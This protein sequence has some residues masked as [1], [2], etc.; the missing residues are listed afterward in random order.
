MLDAQKN[1]DLDDVQEQEPRSESAFTGNTIGMQRES[2]AR[3][4]A[5]LV[6]NRIMSFY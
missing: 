5:G 1:A 6:D 4:R 2:G 3:N